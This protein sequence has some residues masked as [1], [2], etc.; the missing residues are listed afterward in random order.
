MNRLSDPGSG[1]D[2][3]QQLLGILERGHGLWG[4]QHP[5]L[6]LKGDAG[7]QPAKAVKPQIGQGEAGGVA[8]EGL[9]QRREVSRR[10]AD[11]GEGIEQRRQ[12]VG[13]GHQR[14][15]TGPEQSTKK[16]RNETGQSNEGE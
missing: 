7:L 4:E 3:P 6:D 13:G 14:A 5:M 9:C 16:G 1:G 15:E 10:H 11:R 12:G 2:P 8:P